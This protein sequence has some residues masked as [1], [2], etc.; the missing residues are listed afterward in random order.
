MTESQEK[1]PDLKRLHAALGL[2]PPQDKPTKPE[3]SPE[4]A[5]PTPAP[6][7]RPKALPKAE[8]KPNE[9][10]PDKTFLYMI[11]GALLALFGFLVAAFFGLV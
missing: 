9:P 8:R 2:S 6:R 7:A 3:K 4:P 10:P 5:A 1:Q 11:G